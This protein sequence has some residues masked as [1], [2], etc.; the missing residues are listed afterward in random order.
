MLSYS[1]PTLCIKTAD[2]WTVDLVIQILANG[3]HPSGFG[4]KKIKILV[5]LKTDEIHFLKPLRILE[6][7]LKKLSD[8]EY[9]K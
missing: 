5:T 9:M 4:N 6:N 2:Q 7:R 1:H 8:K 3:T